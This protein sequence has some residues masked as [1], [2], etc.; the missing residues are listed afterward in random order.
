[1]EKIL[2]SFLE[3]A[4]VLKDIFQ[5]DIVVAV[6]DTDEFLYYRKGDTLDLHIKIG[7][8]LSVDEPLYKTIHDGEIY[9]V[10]V[11]EEVYDHLSLFHIQ[12]KVHREK[13]LEGLA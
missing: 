3:V 8:K 1:M 7:Q 2:E 10:T 6:A 4:P 11:A 13:L 9:V 5:E 12:L